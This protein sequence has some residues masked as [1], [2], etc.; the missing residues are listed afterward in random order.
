MQ[1][2]VARTKEV[3]EKVSFIQKNTLKFTWYLIIEA[4]FYM[5]IELFDSRWKTLARGKSRVT[6][7]YWRSMSLEINALRYNNFGGVA[8]E[9]RNHKKGY[10]KY[11]VFLI[12]IY[13]QKI[14]CAC[15]PSIRNYIWILFILLKRWVM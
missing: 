4:I 3:H 2:N 1:K 9:V 7:D 14:L 12:N 6:S 8:Q 11:G 15:D 13:W 5:K 10:K